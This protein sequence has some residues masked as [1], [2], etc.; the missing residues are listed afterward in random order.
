MVTMQNDKYD[1]LIEYGTFKNL[2]FLDTNSI[3]QLDLNEQ[4][5]DKK[6]F[7]LLYEINFD[8]NVSVNIFN[9][10]VA[11]HNTIIDLDLVNLI[12][13]FDNINNLP[14]GI[15]LDFNKDTK[16]VDYNIFKIITF[17]KSNRLCKIFGEN[18]ITFNLLPNKKIGFPTLMDEINFMRKNNRFF[19]YD[20]SKF[21]DI[22]Y[23]GSDNY[24]ERFLL[25]ENFEFNGG[26]Y[27]PVNK[28]LKKSANNNKNE[29]NKKTRKRTIPISNINFAN[30]NNKY[31][32]NRIK[33]FLIQ[34]LSYPYPFI[35]MKRKNSMYVGVMYSCDKR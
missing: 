5:K 13:F 26:G 35:R 25:D 22:L 4:N 12:K 24:I 10:I 7:P 11:I 15:N 30:N 27:G 8:S 33:D 1:K 32:N 21:D 16:N 2:E 29:E 9:K 31:N 23:Y 18:T 17:I 14:K 3:L 28:S 34:N 19:M 6:F 20:R